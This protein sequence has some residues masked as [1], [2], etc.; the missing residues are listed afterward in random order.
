MKR[1]P[2]GKQW[3]LGAVLGGLVLL[4]ARYLWKSKVRTEDL[5]PL[6]ALLP[7]SPLVNPLDGR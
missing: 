3:I 2:T 5:D 4:L 7:V 6:L 1:R